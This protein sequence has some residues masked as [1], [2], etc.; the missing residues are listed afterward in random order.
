TAVEPLAHP[1]RLRAGD[2]GAARRRPGAARAPPRPGA[3]RPVR[4]ADAPL[5]GAPSARGPL[6]Q[7]E[8]PPALRRHRSPPRALLALLRGGRRARARR[9]V[10]RPGGSPAVAVGPGLRAGEPHRPLA[11]AARALPRLRG[12]APGLVLPRDAEPPPRGGAARARQPAR[13]P[14]H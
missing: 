1:R 14:P 2:V 11:V 7:P 4:P 12:P 3:R 5:R 6:R 9:G 8:L 10:R 13:R